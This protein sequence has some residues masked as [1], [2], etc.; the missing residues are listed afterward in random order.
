[1]FS[2]QLPRSCHPVPACLRGSI[3]L[4]RLP[5]EDWIAKKEFTEN[6]RPYL[7]CYVELESSALTNSAVSVQILQEQFGIYFKYLDHDY[8]DLKKILDR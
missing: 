3:R 6:N 2:L 4:S 5:I 8:Q 1:M 7:H